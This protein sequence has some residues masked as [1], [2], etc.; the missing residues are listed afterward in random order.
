V[1]PS[2]P[3]STRYSPLTFGEAKGEPRRGGAR[4]VRAVAPARRSGCRLS[5][6]NRLASFHHRR[7]SQAAKNLPFDVIEFE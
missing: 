3:H 7:R 4:R 6:K 2:G 1:N 5:T